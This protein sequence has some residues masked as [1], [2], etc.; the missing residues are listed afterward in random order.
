VFPNGPW[1]AS[2]IWR[3]MVFGDET[4]E[5][6]LFSTLHD[7][8]HSLLKLHEFEPRF[9]PSP[10]SSIFFVDG[11]LDL[12][13]CVCGNHA[14]LG[15]GGSERIFRATTL[16][17][18]HCWWNLSWYTLQ[19]SKQWKLRGLWGA[20]LYTHG[21][22]PPNHSCILKNSPKQF[23]VLISFSAYTEL[24]S[25]RMELLWNWA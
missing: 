6:L 16:V 24:V 8:C 2:T 7:R 3:S 15:E 22:I 13:M 11:P 1:S 4:L 12:S 5:S 9:F 25:S 21:W 18:A 19:V 20:C 10:A 14:Y 23:S 17:Q